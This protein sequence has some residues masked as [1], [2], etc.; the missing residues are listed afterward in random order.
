M[1]A[2]ERELFFVRD[3]VPGKVPVSVQTVLMKLMGGGEAEEKEEKEAKDWRSW[4]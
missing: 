1:A 2:G 3:V 4:C